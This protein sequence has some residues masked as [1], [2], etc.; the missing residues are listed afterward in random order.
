MS[1]SLNSKGTATLLTKGM[2][3]LLKTLN[4]FKCD[5]YTSAKIKVKHLNDV[6]ICRRSK[7]VNFARPIQPHDEGSEVCFLF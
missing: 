4:I 5:I 7:S 3:L 2:W 6:V 1:L